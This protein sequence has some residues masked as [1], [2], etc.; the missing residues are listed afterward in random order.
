MGA[1]GPQDGGVYEVVEVSKDYKA[2]LVV[3]GA[4]DD[5]NYDDDPDWKPGYWYSATA[6]TLNGGPGTIYSGG[7]F[8]I[9]EDENGQLAAAGL[10]PLIE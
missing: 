3:D 8:Y 4:L 6:P 5:V 7:R 10:P 9:A 1:T 2:L